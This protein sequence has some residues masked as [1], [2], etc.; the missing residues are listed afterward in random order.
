MYL[1]DLLPDRLPEAPAVDEVASRRLKLIAALRDPT[2]WPKGFE[3]DFGNCGCCGMGLAR[4]LRIIRCDLAIPEHVACPLGLTEQQSFA[5]FQPWN[6]KAGPVRN[7]LGY[8]A[9]T[10]ADVTAAMVA[11]RLEAV[12][13]SLTAAAVQP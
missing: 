7:P 9:E 6:L 3:W 12:H 4:S 1:K 11:D 5:I 8:R 13:R 10:Y 2:T